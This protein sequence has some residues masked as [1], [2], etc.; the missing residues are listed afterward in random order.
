MQNIRFESEECKTFF[1][2]STV[3]QASQIQHRFSVWK[4]TNVQRDQAIKLHVHLDSTN[5]MHR[6]LSVW[7]AQLVITAIRMRQSLSSKVVQVF[8]HKYICSYNEL[9]IPHQVYLGSA[10]IHKIFNVHVCYILGAPSHGVV[11]PKD[12]PAGF[13]CPNGTETVHQYPCPIGTYSNTTRLENE[14]DCRLCPPGYY[15]EATNITEPTDKCDAG[16]YCILGS[17]SPQPSLPTEGGTCP[18][19]TWCEQ[20]WSNP[21][22]CPKV[23]RFRF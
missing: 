10:L 22:P 9:N 14:G 15:C 23:M 6:R 8:H 11:T 21:T 12:C 4:D 5:Q 7:C 3:H 18:Q 17:S 1:Q 19:G 13:Y 16:Y 2:V 20:G